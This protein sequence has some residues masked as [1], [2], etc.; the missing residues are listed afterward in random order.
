MESFISLGKKIYDM[1]NPREVRRCAVFVARCWL[2]YSRMKKI[3]A[4]YQQSKL[5]RDLAEIYPFVYE[6]P[7]RAFFY[8]KSNFTERMRLLQEHFSFLEQT[9]KSEVLLDIYRENDQ[10]L[11]EN[12]HEGEPLRLVIYY[13]PGQRKEGLLSVILRLGEKPLYQMIFWIQKNP[14]GEWAAYI[15]AMQGPNM[16]NAKDVIK[17]ITKQCHAYRTKNLILH[18]TQEVVRGLGIKHL[19]AVT[20]YGYYANNHVRMD[21]KL[22]TD[23]SKF[24]QESGG[25]ACEDKRFYELPLVEYRK[26][27]DEV[28]TRKRA[29][30]RRRFAL[31]DEIDQS[32]AETIKKLSL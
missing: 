21:R 6:Q 30:Y 16:D 17:K 2:N 1:S 31:L 29:V 10:I 18:A 12:E 14:Q 28:P 24:W 19:Y 11:W 15:G 32:I 23:F 4:F 25:T 20:N 22:K 7:Q 5:R 8:N 9:V 13:E 26:T 27:M 3:D